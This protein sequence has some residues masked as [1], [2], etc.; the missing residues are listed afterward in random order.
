M[1]HRCQKSLTIHVRVKSNMRVTNTISNTARTLAVVLAVACT[2]IALGFMSVPQAQATPLPM[3]SFEDI[4]TLRA[5]FVQNSGA[6][7]FGWGLNERG[8]TGFGIGGA[9]IQNTPRLVGPASNFASDWIQ[10]SAGTSHSAAINSNGELF[11]WGDNRN[12]QLGL[13]HN[14]DVLVPPT[15]VGNATNW[16]QVI[17]GNRFTFAINSNGELWAWGVNT[18][19]HLGFGDYDCRHAPARVGNASNWRQIAAGG[20]TNVVALNSYGQIFHWG[21]STGGPGTSRTLPG[22]PTQVGTAS[23]WRQVAAGQDHFLAINASGELWAWGRNNNVLWH[24]DYFA[25]EFIHTPYQVGSASSWRQVSAGNMLSFAINADGELWSWGSHSSGQTGLGID[26]FANQTTP[27]RVGEARNWVSISA[28]SLRGAMALNSNGELFVWGSR[29]SVARA[30]PTG[31]GNVTTPAK[32]GYALGINDDCR[33]THH[34]VFG[35]SNEP[36]RLGPEP[37]EAN[38]TL[39]KH[40][41]K[42]EGTPDPQAEFIFKV[43]RHAF[44]GNEALIDRLPEVGPITLT[45]S[46]IVAGPAGTVT[47]MDSANIFEG[48]QFTQPGRFTFR[49]GE[50]EGSSGINTPPTNSTVV[51]SLAVYEICVLI[52]PDPNDDMV[53][54]EDGII[55]RRIIDSDGNP[56]P[57]PHKP[58]NITFLNTYTFSGPPQTGLVLASNTSY[59]ALFV[60]GLAFAAV[61]TLNARKRI[62]NLS[63]NWI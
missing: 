54:I 18:N 22:V 25:G 8:R 9:S 45:P 3:P 43:V 61:V 39:T 24:G 6:Y 52:I 41:R 27:M 36:I 19:G 51:Y 48:V 62:E 55:V 10:V 29:D 21:G 50:V 4:R 63:R 53:L 44:N 26:S 14:T 59:V 47:R 17:V 28:A 60:A 49:V 31:S 7:L 12:G 38:L 15:R 57:S 1:I 46:T 30:L 23:N 56:L 32:L 37:A 40:L 13:G 42:P 16:R 20:V 35:F 33:D 58:G 5:P 11:T 34:F 2:V